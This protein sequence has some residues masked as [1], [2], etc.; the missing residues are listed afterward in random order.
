M[1]S[2]PPSRIRNVALVGH[3][4]AGKTTLAEAL[5]AG[6][7]AIPRQGRVEDGTTVSDFEPEEVKRHLSVS[8]A[9]APFTVGDIKINLID[10]PG[11]ADFFGE[12]RAA[13]SVVDLVV[14]VVSAVEGVEAQTLAAWR[15]A[16][17]LGLSRL[18]FVNKLDR[19]RA[20]FDRTLADSRAPSVPGSRPWSFRSARSPRSGESLTSSR[21]RRSSMNPASPRR[22]PSRTT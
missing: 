11:Y 6:A 17:D 8:L 9:M 4:G 19:D 18:V 21:T 20:S 3:N 14:V 12:V 16:A 2:H 15:H 22:A 10:T 5:L 13:S 1:P 7:G